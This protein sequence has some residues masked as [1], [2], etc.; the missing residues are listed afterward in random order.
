VDETAARYARVGG[1][2]TGLYGNWARGISADAEVVALIA[3]LPRPQRQPHLLFAVARLVGSPLVAYADWRDWLVANWSL[4]SAASVG[5]MTQTNEPARCAVLVPALG[6]LDG[7]L[8]MLEIG[9][10]AGLCLYPDRYSYR[11]GDRRLDPVAGESAVLIDVEVE[12]NLPLPV[13]IPTIAWRGG[14]DVN[15]LDVRNP[16]HLAWL[17]VLVPPEA[18]DRRARIRDAATI[19]GDDPPHLTTSLDDAV[20]SV[21]AGT[22]LVI[23][24]MGTLVYLRRPERDALAARIRATGAH[25]LS[26]E[27]AGMVDATADEEL[28]TFVLTLDDR[29][30]A[31]A[32]PHGQRIS[33]R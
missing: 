2:A 31:T 32:A 21:P 3:A 18:D 10:S 8:A 13:R 22:R 33:W 27:A 30:L 9:A 23:V 7:P 6:L 29:I 20:A 19:V 26:F 5:R 16:D 11:F 1:E 12:G 28:G 17:E 14:V 15:P 4:V 24:T 25:W